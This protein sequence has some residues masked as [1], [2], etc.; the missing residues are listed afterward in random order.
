MSSNTYYLKVAAWGGVILLH[1][2]IA[3]WF[4]KGKRKYI[5]F[6]YLV[7]YHLV[8]RH[9]LS[10]DIHENTTIGENLCIWHCFGIAIN[11]ATVIGNNVTIGHNTT[12]GKN[13]GKSPII[14]DNVSISPG[15]SIIGGVRIGACST[16]GIGSVVIKDVEPYSVVAGNPAKIIRKK[17]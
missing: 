9:I 1:F 8:I 10:C 4:T 12:L 5:G 15:C 7:Y 11:P 6:L 17:L 16:I 3:H 14:E 2:R 13:R